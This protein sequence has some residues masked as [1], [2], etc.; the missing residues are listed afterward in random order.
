MSA[1]SMMM[2]R[3]DQLEV[4]APR[5][6]HAVRFYKDARALACLWSFLLVAALVAAAPHVLSSL[7]PHA[8]RYWIL[9]FG[10]FLGIPLL[11]VMVFGVSG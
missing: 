6:G 8:I 4:T 2:S 11:A 3:K 5:A 1:P 9:P 7:A 10:T